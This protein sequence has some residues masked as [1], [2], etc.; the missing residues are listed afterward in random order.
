MPVR[1]QELRQRT[2]L[3]LIRERDV[4]SQKQEGIDVTQ[5]TLSRDLKTLGVTRVFDPRKGY[6]YSTGMNGDDQ[7]PPGNFSIGGITGLVFSGNLAV[8]KTRLGHA[9]GV[10]FE[11]DRLNIPEV[12]GTVGGDD[13]I[14]VILKE[15]TDRKTFMKRLQID[16]GE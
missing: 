1:K 6:R 9:T 11:I 2:I 14:L 3:A 5:A 16:S 15:G 4:G 8:I 12:V 13:T 7:P 10:A